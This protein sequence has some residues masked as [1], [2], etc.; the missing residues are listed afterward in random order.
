MEM[1]RE[2]RAF[3][4]ALESVIAQSVC[5]GHMNT[6]VIQRPDVLIKRL[7]NA[8]IF[9]TDAVLGRIKFGTLERTGLNVTMRYLVQREE[10]IKNFI[11]DNTDYKA[12]EAYDVLAFGIIMATMNGTQEANSPAIQQISSVMRVLPPSMQQALID[13][14]ENIKRLLSGI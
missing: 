9:E 10:E 11:E 5:D 13:S 14:K 6:K 7:V 12:D 8:G 4:K 1:R 2:H 3:V